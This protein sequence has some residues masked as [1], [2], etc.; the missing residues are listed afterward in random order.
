MPPN[1]LSRDYIVINSQMSPSGFP[2]IASTRSLP[3]KTLKIFV[4]VLC[5]CGFLYQTSAF[6]RLYIAY[7]TMVDIQIENPD[8]VELPAISLCNSNRIRRK[9][10][11]TRMPNDCA[12]YAN[13]SLFCFALPKFCIGWQT[14][15]TDTV[16]GIPDVRKSAHI[17]RSVEFTQEFGQRPKD[18]IAGCVVRTDTTVLCKN[19]IPVPAVN[20]D[21]Y[22]NYCVAVESLWGQPNA[23]VKELPITGQISLMLTLHPEDYI[24]Y[25]ELVQAHIFAHDAH[26]IAN[27]MKDGI[28]LEAGKTYDIFVNQ[29]VTVRLPAPYETNCTDYLKLWKENGGYGP[30]TG[31]TCV[32]KCKME[33][34]MQSTGCVAHS[35]SYPNNY[36]ICENKNSFPSNMIRQRCLL[37]CSE[38]CREVSYILRSEVKSDQS[39]KC[40]ED[41]NC[42]K[43]DM[44]LNFIF[45]RLEL[46]KFVHK[47]RYESVEMFSYIGG[48][49]GMWLGI[50][51][52]ALFDFLE[53]LA[54]LLLYLGKGK[55]RVRKNA[56]HQNIYDI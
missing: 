52:I 10:L 16:L 6:L 36:T 56:V 8:V 14:S 26:S 46:E 53:T 30:L 45:N 13:R 39:E 48:Y 34:M 55:R 9:A 49:M 27:P 15:D 24:N 22:L 41:L 32:E 20:S 28:T 4:F 35:I 7:P 37:E 1:P 47:P 17:N 21:G 3:H 18:L 33:S 19:F 31:K 5:I 2:V 43:K 51:L 50:S 12:W 42:K 40:K 38:S 44:F 25:F 23:Q 29:R 54:Y 11:C